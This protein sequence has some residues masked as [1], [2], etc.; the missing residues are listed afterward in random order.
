MSAI[1]DAYAQAFK[2]G[3]V[4][5]DELSASQVMACF[6]ALGINEIHD[7]NSVGLDDL[8]KVGGMTN[9]TVIAILLFAQHHDVKIT[10]GSK[11]P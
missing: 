1:S 6:H 8:S 7:L 11:R 10:R 2:D 9:R 5:D 4:F 3:V